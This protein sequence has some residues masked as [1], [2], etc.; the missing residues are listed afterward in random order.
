[1]LTLI[2][3]RRLGALAALILLTACAVP[4][5]PVLPTPAADSAGPSL[6]QRYADLQASTGGR[7]F[8]VDAAASQVR[9]HVFRAGRAARLGH[10]HV[11]SA[12]QLNGWVL[13]PAEALEGGR[14][15]LEFRL[16]QLELDA[17]A[18]RAA[19]GPAWASALSAEAVAATKL[20]MLGE[21]GLQAERY[22]VVRLRGLQIVGAAPQLAVQVEV[23]LHGQRQT[24]WLALS[25]ELTDDTALR[26]RGALVLRQSDFGVQPFSVAGGLL[27]VQDELVVTF[28]L[29][30][31]R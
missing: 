28:E 14:F 11:L 30:A 20:N 6:A 29:V 27:A 1:M 7:L 18:Q 15:E 19:L 26:T 3:P 10:N 5:R 24:Q 4:T 2:L 12:P 9:V 21:V 17:P 31:K 23:A 8:R 25:T 16:D 22:P 13:L